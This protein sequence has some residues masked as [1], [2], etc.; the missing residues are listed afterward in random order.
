MVFLWKV[1]YATLFPSRPQWDLKFDNGERVRQR[2][3]TGVM[4]R[5]NRRQWRKIGFH[6]CRGSEGTGGTGW[7]HLQSFVERRSTQVVIL[8]SISSLTCLLVC[9]AFL[10]L[11]LLLLQLSFFKIRFW[12]F[13][14]ILRFMMISTHWYSVLQLIFDLFF[15]F[16]NQFRVLK[17]ATLRNQL[18]VTLG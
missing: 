9:F 17:M 15:N 3:G 4:R 2:S 18:L 1:S 12:Y 10:L 6:G 5:G 13:H 7:F 16:T 8:K 11:L 14:T